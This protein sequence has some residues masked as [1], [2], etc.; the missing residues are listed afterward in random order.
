VQIRVCNACARA[1]RLSRF[2]GEKGEMAETTS[3][4]YLVPL[5]EVGPNCAASWLLADQTAGRAVAP[6]AAAAASPGRGPAVDS[7]SSPSLSPF[8]D[9]AASL[10][11]AYRDAL[12]AAGVPIDDFQG[13]ADEIRALPYKYTS[14]T[15]RGGCILLAAVPVRE[16]EGDGGKEDGKADAGAGAESTRTRRDAPL[17]YVSVPG[18]EAPP[19]PTDVVHR[20]LLRCVGCIA[21]KDLGEGVGE[22]KRLFVREE[23]R[24]LGV[25]SALSRALERVA[26][27]G[28]D[29]SS[30]GGGATAETG[31]AS[32]SSSF[33]YSS[34]VLDTLHRLKGALPLYERLGF[35][36]CDAY[37]H[38]PMHDVVFLRKDLGGPRGRKG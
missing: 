21:L 29:D 1:K 2:E 38:N 3:P 7:S 23:A 11:W 31:P 36:Q 24:R 14:S 32:L 15:G 10:I 13:Y 19:V 33:G 20:L 12:I 34:L 16:G 28:L 26:G 17:L 37:V 4:F 8:L 25:A 22:V 27:G 18:D 30:G 5:P 6:V 9:A 35:V